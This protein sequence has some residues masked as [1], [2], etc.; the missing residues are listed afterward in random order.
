MLVYLGA[1]A[2]ALMIIAALGSLIAYADRVIRRQA[3]AI[4][5]S[6]RLATA[7]EMAS[8]VA[9]GLRNPLAAIRSSAELGLWLGSPE[10]TIPLLED[11]V[12]QA[13]RLEHWVRQYLTAAEPSGADRCED[14]E[15][16][17]AMVRANLVGDLER[18]GVEWEES[19]ESKLPPVAIGGAL[20]EQILSGVATNAVQ[21][22]PEG[23]TIR[24]GGRTAGGEV[25]LTLTDTGQGMSAEQLRRVFEPFR[26]TKQAGLGLGLALARRILVRHNG[27]IVI[28]S[29]LGQGT[30]V[31][32]ALPVAP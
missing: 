18:Q 20:L 13:D 7:G 8:A 28:D 17:V 4:A 1:A 23:G 29:E 32:I 22:M 25:E 31:T 6:E 16:V 14:V 21:A 19:F 15:A 5:E 27:R 3:Q 2:G 24:I 12:L 10:R 11:I 30:R 9:H 26:T